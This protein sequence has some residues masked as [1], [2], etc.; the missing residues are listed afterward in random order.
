MNYQK[1]NV[2]KYQKYLVVAFVVALF[3]PLLAARTVE[4]FEEE[5]NLETLPYMEFDRDAELGFETE[6]FLPEGFD[7]YE[8]TFSINAL[9]YIEDDTFEIE[10]DTAAY[11]PENFDAFAR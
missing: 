8:G 11:L 5:F 3:L 4:D 7:P 9:N 2:M 10:F 6:P 1:T